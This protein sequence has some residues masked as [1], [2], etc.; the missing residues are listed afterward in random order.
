MRD[1]LTARGGTLA[2]NVATFPPDVDQVVVWEQCVTETKQIVGDAVTELDPR[3]FDPITER[4]QTAVADN[5]VDITLEADDWERATFTPGEDPVTGPEP[6]RSA[7]FS[8]GTGRSLHVDIYTGGSDGFLVRTE[9][10]YPPLPPE[11]ILTLDEFE[12]VASYPSGDRFRYDLL[13]D[14]DTVLEITGTGFEDV[15]S[16][17]EIV[18]LVVIA[19]DD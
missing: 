12:R 11:D 6:E 1:C 5:S 4:P 18:G 2:G 3:F 7:Q 15:E 19:P 17:L 9:G 14:D 10:E 8:D 16:F 13:R